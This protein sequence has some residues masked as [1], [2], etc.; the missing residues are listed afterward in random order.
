MLLIPQ[1]TPNNY[2]SSIVAL[3]IHSPNDTG[4]WHSTA[5]LRDDT[6]PLSFYFYGDKQENNT[7]HLLGNLGVIDATQRLKSMGY[8]PQNEPV[9][10]A[11]PPRAYVDYLY[12]DGLQTGVINSAILDD[13]FPSIEDKQAV[14]D[15][16]AVLEP[17]LNEN[18]LRNLQRWKERNPLE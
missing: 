10:V 17:K 3:N 11:D 16:L 13:W 9:W 5:S 12:S 2:I 7:N 18:E 6:F 14:Y 15:I 1:T 8:N 4:D